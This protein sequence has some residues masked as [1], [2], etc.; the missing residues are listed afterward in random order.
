[1]IEYTSTP[2]NFYEDYKSQ[3][4]KVREKAAELEKRKKKNGRL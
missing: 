1:M 2:T 3:L 4:P